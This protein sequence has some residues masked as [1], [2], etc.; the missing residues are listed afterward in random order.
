[1]RSCAIAEELI[2]RGEEV[3]FVGETKDLPWVQQ[4]VSDWGFSKI[5]DLES[6]FTPSPISD[7]LIVDSYGLDPESHFFNLSN[8][9]KIVVIVDEAT[10]KYR[11]HLYI[12]PGARVSWQPPAKT[13]DFLFLSGVEFIPIRKSIQE[14]SSI[15]RGAANNSPNILISGGGSD[16]LNFCGAMAKILTELPDEF[17]ATFFSEQSGNLS[18]DHRFIFVPIG[19]RIE[20]Y[21]ADADLIFTTAGTSSWEFLACGLPLGIALG[22]ENQAPNYLYLTQAGIALGLGSWT[23]H[24]EW[25]LRKD[26]IE[27]LIRDMNS[28]VELSKRARNIV[29]G[30][31]S[32]RIVDSIIETS[33]IGNRKPQS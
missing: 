8:W 16:S 2:S 14:F 17:T 30:K 13:D 6:D 20:D 24:Q 4:R 27:E 28:R 7:V 22:F 11:A 31:G 25:E 5:Y 12:H 19:S 33:T 32:E 1:M 18:Y 26:L 15:N 3:I 9:R 10:P 23:N 21:L 29:D